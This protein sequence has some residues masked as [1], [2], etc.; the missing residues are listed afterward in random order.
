MP[1][2]SIAEVMTDRPE[3][4][5]KQIVSHLGRKIAWVTEDGVSTA[6]LGTATASIATTNGRLILTASGAAT[7][8]VEQ[9]ENGLASHVHRFAS[10][11]PVAISWTREATTAVR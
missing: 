4:Y 1:I 7:A 8:E 10:R 3:R 2:T 6:S 11:E 9:I 5:G